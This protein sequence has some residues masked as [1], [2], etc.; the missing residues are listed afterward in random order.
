MRLIEMAL[1]RHILFP[2]DAEVSAVRMG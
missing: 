2:H 1:R